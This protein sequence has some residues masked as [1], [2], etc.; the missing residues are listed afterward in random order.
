MYNIE[1]VN[2]PAPSSISSEIRGIFRTKSDNGQK[3]RSELPKTLNE[4]SESPERSQ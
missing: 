2:A 4:S 1:P 3:I